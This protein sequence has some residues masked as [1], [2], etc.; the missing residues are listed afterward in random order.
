MKVH[1]YESRVQWEPK[2]EESTR[3][4]RSYSRDHMAS[5]PNKMM[6][7]AMSSDPSFLGNSKRYNPEELLL[8]SLS[9]C[10]MLWYLHLCSVNEVLVLKYEDD[11]VGEMLETDEGGQFEKV[12]LRPRVTVA[13]SSMIT[14]AEALHH[15]A[16]RACFIARSV[17]FTVEHEVLIMVGGSSAE[18]STD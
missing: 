8:M 16:N 4:Y 12:T 1:K 7:V 18:S 2:L 11:T 14:R 17:N 10:H 13:N 6:N 5:S 9:S 3:H 15:D